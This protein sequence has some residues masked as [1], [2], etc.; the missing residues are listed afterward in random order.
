MAYGTASNMKSP[1]Q[2][3]IVNQIIIK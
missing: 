1:K 2:S 3:P